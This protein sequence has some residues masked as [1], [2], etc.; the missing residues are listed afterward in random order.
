M[1]DCTKIKRKCVAEIVHLA[2]IWR[3]TFQPLYNTAFLCYYNSILTIA[4]KFGQFVQSGA[5]LV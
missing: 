2:K 4:P 1:T 5:R 3:L